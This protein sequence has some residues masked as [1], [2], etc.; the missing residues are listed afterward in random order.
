MPAPGF[1]GAYPQPRFA[2]PR[3]YAYQLSILDGAAAVTMVDNVITVM[4]NPLIGYYTTYVLDERFLPWSS[5]RW[6]LDFIVAACTWQAY[7]DGVHHLQAFTVN[8]WFRG[9]PAV[10]TITLVN[11]YSSPNEYFL[12]L[13]HQPADYWSPPPFT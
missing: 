10:P 4:F 2:L 3:S 8:H 6:T 13:P 5:N 7:F 9:V 11:P 12:P 1:L